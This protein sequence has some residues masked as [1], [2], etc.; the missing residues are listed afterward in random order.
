MHL[1]KVETHLEGLEDFLFRVS[2]LHLA[3]HESQEFWEVNCT[4][5][6]RIH[7]RA[8]TTRSALEKLLSTT[9]TLLSAAAGSKQSKKY[10]TA[11]CQQRLYLV[12]HVLKLGLS[13]VLA[14]RAHHR[15][16]LLGGDSAVTILVEQGERLLKLGNLLLCSNTQQS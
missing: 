2:I 12:N 11:E 3:R 8:H 4:V 5:A 9:H 10:S 14:E 15:A 7:L 6:I 1:R 13:R 16:Q